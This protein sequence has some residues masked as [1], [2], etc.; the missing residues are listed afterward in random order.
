MFPHT[1]LTSDKSVQT[2]Q[3]LFIL[4]SV[5]SVLSRREQ[6]P[7]ILFPP[8]CNSLLFF[9]RGRKIKNEILFVGLGKTF[10]LWDPKYFEKFKI[11][12]RK[13][14]FKNRESL[15]WENKQ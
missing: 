2:P 13:K 7:V 5:Q 6:T 3:G 8:P 11:E 15:K 4:S 10:Q 14:A 1:E 9:Q 12:A